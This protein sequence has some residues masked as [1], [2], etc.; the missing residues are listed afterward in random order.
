MLVTG[1]GG[2][3]A[4]YIAL[5]LLEQGYR[6]RGSL[7]RIAAG[8]NIKSQL[9]A[10]THADTQNLSFVEADLNSDDGW[11]A[12]VKGCSYVVHTASPFPAGLPKDENALIRTARDGALRVLRVAH[13]ERVKRV[14]ARPPPEPL[15]QPRQRASALYRR[16]LDGPRKPRATPYYKSKTLTE[17]AA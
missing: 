3:L 14:G 2:F 12:A 5:Q 9:G 13:R 11:A 4:W 10:H 1:A 7:R 17:Q 8:D 6:V 15:R 16:K